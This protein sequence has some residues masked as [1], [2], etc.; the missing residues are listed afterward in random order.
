MQDRN[1]QSLGINK[2]WSF[3][4]NLTEKEKERKLNL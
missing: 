2:V 4:D 1:S 3:P